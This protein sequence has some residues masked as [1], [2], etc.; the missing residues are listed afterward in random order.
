MERINERPISINLQPNSYIG[1]KTKTWQP[2][3]GELIAVSLDVPSK[4][5]SQPVAPAGGWIK[6]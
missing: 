3:V 1:E 5:E 6:K 2:K 4:I